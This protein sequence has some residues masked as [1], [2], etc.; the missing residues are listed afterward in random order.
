[1]TGNLSTEEVEI[2]LRI[3]RDAASG[4]TFEE[5]LQLVTDYLTVLVPATSI[6]TM[7]L[8]QDGGPPAHVMV[9]NLSTENLVQYALH[10]R[11]TD[12]MTMGGQLDAATGH[13][14]LLSDF[15]S[16][17]QFGRDQFTADFLAKQRL[18]HIL[19]ASMRMPDG[20]RLVVGIQRESSLGDFTGKERQLIRLMCPDLARAISG[21]LLR[22]KI[23]RLIADGSAAT[24]GDPSSGNVVFNAHGDIV[25][26]DPEALSI[27]EELGGAHGRFP[28]DL[29]LR[30]VTR[31]VESSTNEHQ[32]LE[33]T[34]PLAGGGVARIR[35]QILSDRVGQRQ[36]LATFKLERADRQK[37]FDALA[38]RFALTKRERQVAELVIQGDGNRHVGYKLGLSEI[39]VGTHLTSIY[40]KAGVSGRTDLVRLFLGGAPGKPHQNR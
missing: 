2:L 13:P 34:L 31:L 24:S 28:S 36:V 22:E 9:R 23:A 20:A 8:P 16:S 35:L 21:V 5:R 29:L 39:T 1:M 40:R 12:P 6:S 33:R 3:A 4:D 10:Y 19:G 26:A 11:H 25:E 14:Y 27:C 17:Q 38:E 15:V 30:D 37:H 18:R 7:V 32:Q